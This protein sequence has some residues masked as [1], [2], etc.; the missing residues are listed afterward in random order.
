MQGN[1]LPNLAE[2]SAQ[3]LNLSQKSELS[4][5]R[6]KNDMYKFWEKNA[7][8]LYEFSEETGNGKMK[9]ELDA[10]FRNQAKVPGQQNK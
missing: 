6:H 5:K 3:T 10:L 9:R 7:E 1:K 8:H 4:H 2:L